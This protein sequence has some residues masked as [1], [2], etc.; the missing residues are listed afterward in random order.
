M[1][2][3]V[4]SNHPS[5][6][7]VRASLAAWET[8]GSDSGVLGSVGRPGNQGNRLLVLVKRTRMK[9]PLINSQALMTDTTGL[10]WVQGVQSLG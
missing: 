8:R 9:T 5:F 4:I 3:G 1:P 7:V 6:K 10:T 2:R